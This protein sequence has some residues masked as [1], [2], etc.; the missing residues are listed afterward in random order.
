MP[1]L[2]GSILLGL[3]GGAPAA[4]VLSIS[5][6]DL[7]FPSPSR[8]I[9]A[10]HSPRGGAFGARLDTGKDAKRRP[11]RRERVPLFI[12]RASSR[13]RP[14]TFPNNLVG[15]AA[16]RHRVRRAGRNLVSRP[17]LFMRSILSP[18]YFVISFQALRGV[19]NYAR[20]AANN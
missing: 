5:R 7:R 3:M 6:L 8:E 1:R 20:M 19:P 15:R 16:R 11:R 10:R 9:A 14:V 2:M 17:S 4:P 12:R 18:W 13:R